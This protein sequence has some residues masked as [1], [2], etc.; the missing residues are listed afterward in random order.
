MSFFNLRRGGSSSQSQSGAPAENLDTVRKRA[1]HRLIGAAVLVLVG[2]VGF[3]LLFD[4]QPRPIPVDIAIE[5]PARQSVKPLA[6]ATPASAT[7]VPSAAPATP[8]PDPAPV[9]PPAAVA[10]VTPV[11]AAPAAAVPAAPRVADDSARAK[12]LLEDKPVVAANESAELR[13]VVQVGAFADAAKAREVRLKLEKA[14]LKTYTQVAD[15]K[16][17]KRTRVR[18][19]PFANKAEADQAALKIKALDLP[20]TILSL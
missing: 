11:P 20:A 1:K 19:G 15:S 9:A 2:V 17:G 14:G 8:A 7:P 10:S 16:E 6:T 18:V 3:P 5:I 12:A 4:S 13:L